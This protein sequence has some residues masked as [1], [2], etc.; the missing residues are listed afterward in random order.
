MITLIIDNN[1]RLRK[2]TNGVSTN[3]V[4]ADLVVLHRV[5]DSPD[6]DEH[7]V[8][9]PALLRAIIYIYIY[10][11]IYTCCHRAECVVLRQTSFPE[12]E[13]KSAIKNEAT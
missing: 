7:R 13:P 10:I 4:T 1:S 9:G 12:A 6:T 11:Y 3:G 5:S 8:A 2:W